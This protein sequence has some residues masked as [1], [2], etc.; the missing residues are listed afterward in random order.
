MPDK[1]FIQVVLISVFTYLIFFWPALR[2]E[3]L[4]YSGKDMTSLHYPARV[5][6]HEKLSGG[7]F[8]FWTE[9]MFLGFPIYLDLE[10]G[11]LN[12]FNVLLVGFLGPILSIKILHFAFYISGS[13]A[14]YAFLRKYKVSLLGFFT[15][16]LVYFLSFFMLYHQ[17][18]FNMIITAYSLPLLLYLVDLIAKYKSLLYVFL[19]SQVVLCLFYFGSFQM[20]FL[21]FLA[22]LIYLFFQD[23][24]HK[25]LL[26]TLL[27]LLFAGIL[28]I[29]IPLGEL[30]LNSARSLETLFTQGSFPPH[31]IGNLIFPFAFGL[32]EE[33]MGIIASREYFMHEVYTYGGITSATFAVLGYFLVGDKK[34]KKFIQVLAGL[35]LFLAFIKFIPLI[36]VFKLPIL[37]S[38]RYWGRS[39]VL[40]IFAIAC[41]VS[42]FLSQLKN[43][44]WKVP[45]FLFF[46][47]VFLIALEILNF[48]KTRITPALDVFKRVYK[49]PPTYI[50]VWLGLVVILAIALLVK[51]NVLFL[52]SLLVFE[53]MFFGILATKDLFKTRQELFRED[54]LN[55]SY[56]Q[57]RVIDFTNDHNGNRALFYPQWGLLGYSQFLPSDVS[58]VISQFSSSSRKADIDEALQGDLSTIIPLL[59]QLG[60]NTVI[61]PFGRAINVGSD[62]FDPS[63]KNV[64]RE[65]G[66]YK[67]IA[68]G[69]KVQTRVRYDRGW[70]LWIDDNP[71]SIT[72]EGMFVSFDVPP[73]EHGFKLLYLPIVF[74]RSLIVAGVMYAGLLA[75][76]LRNRKL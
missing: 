23:L 40:L 53:L 69:P 5:Y 36:S 59:P 64:L 14:F 16:N 39:V 44:T 73:G 68:R 66:Y 43:F 19:Y 35:F 48:G 20:L 33:Y 22:S 63:V 47:T 42:I 10:R 61:D 2:G 65:E 38:F 55:G 4:L 3:L 41:L 56:A 67:G 75:Y 58:G 54:V 1:K 29:L 37:A 52:T 25:K 57:Q 62:V 17:Q 50:Y 26:G 72:K 60:I 49:S 71:T 31:F 18:H 46:P 34:L 9:R 76:I 13:L 21:V 7:Q 11:Y 51:R 30:Y 8:P 45:K 24:A 15:A 74:F 27:A 6:L 28:P 70:K 32:G 12:V